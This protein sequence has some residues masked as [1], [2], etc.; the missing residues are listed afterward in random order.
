MGG[1]LDSSP[2]DEGGRLPAPR[3]TYVLCYLGFGV[4][5]ASALVGRDSRPSN[6][7]ELGL[8][9]TGLPAGIDPRIDPNTAS[10]NE[11]ACLPGIG[12]VLAKRIVEYRRQQQENS[13]SVAEPAVVFRRPADLDAVRGIGPKTIARLGPHLRFPASAAA[14]G[15]QPER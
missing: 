10:W 5:L 6:C 4:I 2:G 14:A 3:W 9:S 7:V 13:P 1:S 11:L 8:P 12:E 15:S